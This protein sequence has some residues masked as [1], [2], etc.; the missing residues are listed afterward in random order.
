MEWRHFKRFILFILS[1]GI[2]SVFFSF[3]VL[4]AVDS[5]NDGYSDESE[6]TD[7][8]SPFNPEAVRADKSDVDGDGLSDLME[9][10]F[11]TDPNK[12]DT[13]NDGYSDLQELDRSF[14]PLSSSTKKLANRIEINL[15]KQELTYFIGGVAWR[16]YPVSTGKASM[17]TPTGKFFVTNKV[18]KAWSGTYKLWMPYWLGL[19]NGSFGIH[20]LPLWPS[21]YREGED[22]LGK[23]VSHGCIRLGIGPAQYLYERVGTGTEV[24]IKSR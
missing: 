8:Y 23:P 17:P 24:I 13:D 20:E 7:N 3:P 11:K 5:D 22:H 12:K 2:A 1:F 4:A 21:G 10:R 6:I 9:W 15:Q 19:G 18:K 14:D 16:R